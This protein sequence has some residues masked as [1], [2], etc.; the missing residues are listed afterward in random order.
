MELLEFKAHQLSD[1]KIL[2]LVKEPLND[3][4]DQVVLATIKIL[5]RRNGSKI[6]FKLAEKA[7]EGSI[8]ISR[9][10]IIA[11]GSMETKYSQQQLIDLRE[12]LAVG[13]KQEMVI[14]QLKQQFRVLIKEKNN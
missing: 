3:F 10:A 14:Q 9:S 11:L 1:E 5:K 6:C 4:R 12:E 7:K 2:D 13:T 8:E